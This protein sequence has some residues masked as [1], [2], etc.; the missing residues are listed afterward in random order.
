MLGHALGNA[1]FCYTNCPNRG[2]AVSLL[3]RLLY[4]YGLRISE[5]LGLKMKDVDLDSGVLTVLE[6]KFEK[7][8]YVPMAPELTERCRNYAKTIV[9][10]FFR[11]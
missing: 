5:A 6:S 3:I 8:R 9:L 4:G 1:K 7:N 11:R 2:A 10:M